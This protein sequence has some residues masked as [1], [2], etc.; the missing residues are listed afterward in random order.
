M[1]ATTPAAYL[2]S[3][4]EPRRGPARKL[5]ELIRAT[6]PDLTPHIR[7]GMIGYG[8]YLVGIGFLWKRISTSAY[9]V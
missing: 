5:H 7:A 8:A 2:K 9:C 1:E 3:L 4:P 6:V